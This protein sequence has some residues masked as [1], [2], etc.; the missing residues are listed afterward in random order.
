MGTSQ[1]HPPFIAACA[2]KESQRE[3]N[4]TPNPYI[5]TTLLAF[6]CFY[7]VSFNAWAL[8]CSYLLG[9]P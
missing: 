7:L 1:N 6:R 2:V 4:I 9:S 3:V 5:T 8:G